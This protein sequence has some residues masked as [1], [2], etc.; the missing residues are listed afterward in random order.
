[1]SE[2]FDMTKHVVKE[3]PDAPYPDEIFHKFPNQMKSH[4]IL[5][6]DVA[7]AD[8]KPEDSEDLS[9]EKDDHVFDIKSNLKENGIKTKKTAPVEEKGAE[10]NGSEPEDKDPV[11]EIQHTTTSFS[12]D[13]GNT[14]GDS[15]DDDSTKTFKN[16]SHPFDPGAFDIEN[17]QNNLETM[18]NSLMIKEFMKLMTM[19]TMMKEWVKVRKNKKN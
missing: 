8:E 14:V 10:Q 18:K 2:L 1:M 16:K 7:N 5:G 3:E 9:D 13:P 11:K 15:N 17:D 4:A 19:P 6:P 12:F